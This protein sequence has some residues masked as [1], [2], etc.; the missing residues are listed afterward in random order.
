[1]SNGWGWFYDRL[2]AGTYIFGRPVVCSIRARSESDRKAPAG[3]TYP[4]GTGVF[5]M[6][7]HRNPSN[8]YFRLRDRASGP[9]I[10]FPGRISAEF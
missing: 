5:E 6:H 10:G 2:E 7:A 3:S 8:V 1:M 9:E 4:Y